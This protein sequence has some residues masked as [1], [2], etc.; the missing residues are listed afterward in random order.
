[1]PETRSAEITRIATRIQTHARARRVES[2]PTFE[3]AP[4]DLGGELC[5][6]VVQRRRGRERR[7]T[8]CSITGAP[9]HCSPFAFCLSRPESSGRA[10]DQAGSRPSVDAPERRKPA[11]PVHRA[12]AEH[13]RRHARKSALDDSP[14]GK[15][16]VPP[17]MPCRNSSNVRV[18]REPKAVLAVLMS[19]C[20]ASSGESGSSR[21]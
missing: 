12:A 9:S 21:S 7:R 15:L 11:P 16:Q 3:R 20:T 2:R 8:P 19:T 18:R 14:F 4:P 5:G 6:G 1:M 13:A 10:A 17:L